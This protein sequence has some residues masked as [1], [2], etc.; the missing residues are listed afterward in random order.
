M[1]DA[2]YYKV[3]KESCFHEAKLNYVL[4]LF[5][6]EL[7]KRQKYKNYDG[8]DAIH[9]YL[10]NKYKWIPS[11]VKSLDKEE[12]RFLLQDEMEGW[13]IPPEANVDISS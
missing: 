7:A 12:I 8:L 5:G 10:I 6:N 9:F 13:T 3:Y 11:Q 1:E 2:E 4:L